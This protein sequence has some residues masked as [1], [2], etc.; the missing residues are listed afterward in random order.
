MYATEKIIPLNLTSRPTYADLKPKPNPSRWST[1]FPP[2]SLLLPR[3]SLLKNP[4]L[5]SDD[6][7]RTPNTPFQQR[8]PLPCVRSDEPDARASLKSL[9][10][11]GEETREKGGGDG[12]RESSVRKREEAGEERVS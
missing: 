5:P 9:R 10:V 8:D 4:T 12:G 3:A 11:R 2:L 1:V 6:L 7:L